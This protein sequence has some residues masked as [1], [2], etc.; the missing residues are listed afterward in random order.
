MKQNF[1]EKYNE[2]TFYSTQTN[3]SNRFRMTPVK[4]GFF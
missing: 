1:P 2:L 3:E 4:N